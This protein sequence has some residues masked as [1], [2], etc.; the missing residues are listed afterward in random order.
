MYH[1]VVIESSILL[2]EKP[3]FGNSKILIITLRNL[4]RK[5][6]E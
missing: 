5:E 3:D 1:S 6:K 2:N 4:D